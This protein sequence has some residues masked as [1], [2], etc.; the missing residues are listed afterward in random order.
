MRQW[1]GPV[2]IVLGVSMT[3]T[4]VRMVLVEGSDADGVTVDHDTFEV[5]AGAGTAAA[6]TAE[7]V[8]AAI[9]GTR[10]SA[11][12]GGHRLVSAG[13]AWTDHAA[14]AHLR[15][16]LQTRGID[17]VVLVSEM[18]AA[19]A[20]A[21]AI[22]QTVDCDRTALVFLEG[23]T[24]TLAV[25][26]TADG[27]VVKVQSDAAAA[28]SEMIAGLE[29]LDAPPQAVFVMG[30]GVGAADVEAIRS[31][32]AVRTTLP[33][34]APQDADLALARGAALACAR[35]PR[36]EAETVGLVPPESTDT[37]AG[38]TQM[39]P[40]GYMAPLGYSAVPDDGDESAELL[41]YEDDPVDSDRGAESGRKP[42]LLVG[43]ALSAFFIL[44]VGALV[45]SLAVSVRPAVNQRP[46]PGSPVPAPGAIANPA[47]APSAVPE[48]IQAP[49]PVVQQAPRTVYVTP[50]PQ[51]PVVMPV[52]PAPA[53][54]A[55]VEAA[56]VAPAPA[57]VAP[58]P[59]PV[60]TPP[61][62]QIIPPW[63]RGPQL[64]S[65]FL[66]PGT[67]VPPAQS[68]PAQSYPA[69]QYPAQSTPSQTTPAQSAPTQSAPAQS[70]PA[71]SAPAQSTPVQSAPVQSTPT[72]SSAGSA[73]ESSG[74]A[75]TSSGSGAPQVRG[76]RRNPLWPE[77]PPF[78]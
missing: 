76:D 43:S 12:E 48:T 63:L 33:V 17:N 32:I 6:R 50:V 72:G 30:S 37:A 54:P 28:M 40:A 16:A 68:Y 29:A 27:A 15:D 73:A 61:V 18:H 34:H 75:G 8:V 47:P 1:G 26:Q 70:A 74:S 42:F 10:E 3:P 66:P 51:A 20:L 14:A 67:N 44:G 71:Q 19:G 60:A 4:A 13:V 5:A 21:Q 39:A 56:P 23:D 78:G 46:D 45:V 52:A 62:A 11:A 25:V 53:A 38:P 7:Q 59:I 24:A 69:Q 35:T 31:Q 55:P 57:Q 49:V 58:V 22:G 64:P 2:E 9:L 41:G 65:I 36:Y 77:W